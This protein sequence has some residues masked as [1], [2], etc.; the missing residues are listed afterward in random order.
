MNTNELIASLSAET[1]KQ[2]MG[3]PAYYT[4]RLGAVLMAYALGAQVFLGF[5]GDL[6]TQFT[7]PMFTAEILLLVLLTVTSAS[8]AIIS[9][10]PD[11]Y[12]K[13]GVLKLPYTAFSLLLMAMLFQLAMP[14]DSMMVLPEMLDAHEMECALCIASVAM[15]PSALIFGLLRKGASVRPVHSGAFAVL[16]ASAI[17]CLTLRLSEANDSLMHIVQWHYVPTILFASL[18]A[19]IGK[20]WL[21]W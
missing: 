8:A 21:K 11:A 16:A 12:Q 14:H 3:T 15:V 7:R 17:G 5:R 19:L 9:M 13:R 1:P 6:L 2:P 4:L 18:G 20:Y 10:Y